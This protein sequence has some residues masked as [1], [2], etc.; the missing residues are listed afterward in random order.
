M[1]KTDI[2]RNGKKAE[3]EK[4][5]PVNI[6]SKKKQPLLNMIMR[7]HKKKCSLLLNIFAH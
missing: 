4:N 7:T 6:L 2:K 1:K 5:H 3:E